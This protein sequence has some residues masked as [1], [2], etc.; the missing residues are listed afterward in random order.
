MNYLFLPEK[1]KN[2]LRTVIADKIPQLVIRSSGSLDGSSG[3]GYVIFDD[4]RI[5]LY[6]RKL[7][8]DVYEKFEGQ[9]GINT[10]PVILRKDKLSSYLDVNIAGREFSIKLSGFED[11]EISAVCERLKTSKAQDI[12]EKSVRGNGNIQTEIWESNFLKDQKPQKTITPFLLL[13]AGIMYVSSMDNG[14]SNEEDSYITTL[15][16]NDQ[17]FLRSALIFYK[18]HSFQDYIEIAACTLNEEQKFCILANMIEISMKDDIYQAFE[19]DMIDKFV[20][21]MKI[22]TEKYRN[23]EEALLI[24]NNI[25]ILA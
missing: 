14:I 11:R 3:E 15:F 21:K 24:K 8:Q 12:S 7:G 1:L 4:E 16:Q 10:G 22:P 25:S 9:I 2:E 17:N 20:E 13:A 5:F 18:S 6:S 23:I 19:Q